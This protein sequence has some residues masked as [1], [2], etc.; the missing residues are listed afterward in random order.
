MWK[1]YLSWHSPTSG[2]SEMNKI[3]ELGEP[4]LPCSCPHLFGAGVDTWPEWRCCHSHVLPPW[5]WLNVRRDVFCQL[6]RL[7]YTV[8]LNTFQS[9]LLKMY[10]WLMIEMSSGTSKCKFKCSHLLIKLK[11]QQNVRFYMSVQSIHLKQLVQSEPVISIFK[12]VWKN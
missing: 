1:W 7:S 11:H 3:T 4:S 8:V 2:R 10:R 6:G 5:P 12:A 9:K